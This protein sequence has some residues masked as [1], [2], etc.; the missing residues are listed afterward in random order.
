M[1]VVFRFAAAACAALFL[2]TPA[3]AQPADAKTA[4]IE[5]YADAAGTIYGD[6]LTEARKLQTSVDLLLAQPTAQHLELARAAWRSARVPYLQ[7][8][9]YRFANAVIDEWEPRV[10]AWPVDEGLID[11]VA[12]AYGTSS[13]QNPFYAANIIANPHLNVGGQAIDASSID[14]PLLRR[15]QQAEGVQTNVATGYHAIEF[16]LWGQDLHGT[17]PGAGERPAGDYDLKVCAHAGCDRRAAY[18]KAATGLLVD[19]LAEMAASWKPGGKARAELER[20]GVDGG[21]AEVLTGMGALSFG[22]M[23]GERM[24]LGLMLHDPEEEQDCFSD[25]TQN[26][27]FYDQA[28]IIAAW[29]GRYQR[30]DGSVVEGPSLRAYAI[31]ADPASASRLDQALEITRARIAAI[32]QA[33]DS[34]HMAYDQMLA[35][36]NAE[37][38][39]LIQD[40]MDALALQ[41]RAIEAVALA[42]RLPVTGARGGA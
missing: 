14:K 2:A 24:K 12:P 25:N 5:H 23:A 8:E 26:S 42:L 30:P 16:L 39:R 36:G 15:L 38:G 33:A 3:S 11:Y 35:P 9:A 18:L 4:V 20:K 27:H 40:A 37:G 6:A 32:K 21:L 7:S 29:T 1:P 34:G 22:E 10:N 28:G 13:D 19:D 31:S 17:G 41:T